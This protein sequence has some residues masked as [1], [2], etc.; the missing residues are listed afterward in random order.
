MVRTGTGEANR[1]QVGSFSCVIF[2]QN[3]LYAADCYKN[4]I[5]VFD[6]KRKALTKIRTI[7]LRYKESSD[8]DDRFF[9]LYATNN[10]LICSSS[11]NH[12]IYV[13]SSNGECLQTYGKLGSGDE[14]C[15]DTPVIGDSDVAGCVLVADYENNRLQVMSEQGEFF[16]LDLQSE[17]SKP[18]VTAIF[19]DHLYVASDW[20]TL[21]KYSC[22]STE[23]CTDSSTRPSSSS[24]S[25]TDD[26]DIDDN[27]KYSDF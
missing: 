23:H 9:K 15:L 8:I 6:Y 1:L 11:E 4:E 14:G 2:H 19:N 3:Q 22:G 5:H 16:V 21:Y 17:V 18:S 20:R 25:V 13:Y 24:G 7:K 27:A 26:H 10:R 12:E